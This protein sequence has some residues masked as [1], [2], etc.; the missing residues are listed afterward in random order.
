[1]QSRKRMVLPQSRE[2]EKPIIQSVTPA[3]AETSITDAMVELKSNIAAAQNS[4]SESQQ[5]TSAKAAKTL[6]LYEIDD[7]E[8]IFSPKQRVYGKNTTWS[9]EE[10]EELIRIAKQ[11]DY[12]TESESPVLYFC[13]ECNGAVG[14]EEFGKNA[15]DSIRGK[16]A[17]THPQKTQTCRT[18]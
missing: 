15:P 1:M 17:W 7:K 3:I 13:S 18:S 8:I 6:D 9:I 10:S 11:A 5:S 4:Q 14:T 16:Y 2:L 12:N